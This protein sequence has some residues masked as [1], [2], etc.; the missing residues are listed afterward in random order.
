M[1][2]PRIRFTDGIEFNT[3]GPVR[4]EER[5]DGLYVVGDGM[6]CPVD[7]REQAER[8]IAALKPETRTDG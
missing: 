2:M 3:D 6:L 7:S 8:V 5:A 4:I 1:L